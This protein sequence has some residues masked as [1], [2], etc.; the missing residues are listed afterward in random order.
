MHQDITHLR[1]DNIEH[2]HWKED[3]MLISAWLNISTDPIVGTDQKEFYSNVTRGVVACKKRWYKINKAIAQFAGC[4]DQT[5]SG[6]NADYIKELAYKLYSTNYGQ[7][8]LLRGIRICFVWSKNGEAKLPTQNGGSKRSKISAIGAYLSSSNSKTPFA[9]ETSVDSC[10][11]PQGSKNNKRKD[12][13]NVR[14]KKLMD[15][16]KE[17]EEEREHRTKIMAIKEKELQMQAA[18]K[19]KKWR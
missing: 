7:K 8:S 15:R 14:E 12:I 11:R 17:R 13:K 1:Q 19:N 5:R 18:M 6:S 2:Q 10:V 16:K 9:D 3:E 4:Y